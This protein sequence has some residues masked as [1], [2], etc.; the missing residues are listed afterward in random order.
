MSNPKDPQFMAEQLVSKLKRRQLTGSM[1]ISLETV[2]VL[3]QIVSVGRWNNE[4]MLI[5]R[6]KQVGARLVAAQPKEII[7]GNVVRRVLCLIREAQVNLNKHQ[8]SQDLQ[9][10]AM[11]STANCPPQFSTQSSMSTLFGDDTTAAISTPAG[12]PIRTY[13]LETSS[14]PSLVHQIKSDIIQAIQDFIEEQEDM[15]RNIATQAMEHI[16]FNEVIM[17]CGRSKTVELFLKH[18]AKKRQFKVVVAESAPFYHG[19]EMALALA[20]AGIDTTVITDSAVFGMMARVNKVILGTS[21]VLA[22]GGLITISG[23]QLIAEAARHHSVPVVVCA[24]LFKLSPVFPF[25][26][27]S[28]NTCVAPDAVLNFSHGDIVSKV[29]VISPF[30]DYVAPEYINLFITNQGGHP[31]TYLYRLLEE[32]YDAEDTYLV[33]A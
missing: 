14:P 26:E 17:T 7:I 21:A 22:N 3:R 16:H 1:A 8:S 33:K 9:G 12:A 23:T 27:D 5:Q 11:D 31:P 28:L 18:A 10:L 19:H 20:N 32:N 29:D 30:Y 24:G 6:I 25:D 15:Y 2:K 13:H 4:D